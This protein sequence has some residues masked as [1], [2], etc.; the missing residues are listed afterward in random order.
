MYKKIFSTILFTLIFSC[1]KAHHIP[2]EPDSLKRYLVTV[3]IIG[4]GQVVLD[5]I[6]PELG[7]LELTNVTARAIETIDMWFFTN[8]GTLGD[9][10]TITF[11]VTE[12]LAIQALFTFDSP[13]SPTSPPD[14][15]EFTVPDWGVT[16][17]HPA[18]S[19]VTGS[20]FTI[21]ESGLYNFEALLRYSAQSSTQE[22][23]HCY[24]RVCNDSLDT[25]PSNPNHES[26]EFIVFDIH[27]EER[28]ILFKEAGQF[29]L[30]AGD[31][32][33]AAYHGST[34]MNEEFHGAN[35]VQGFAFKLSWVE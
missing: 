31:Y 32:F 30:S 16:V 4:Q 29:Q 26:G 28:I 1:S 18:I 23:E 14:S 6:Q 22:K 11:E 25:K 2:M 19:H 5:P 9:S 10:N 20:E 35:S 13:P 24:F 12:A 3:E 7:Y 34:K 21:L 15:I 8:F 33:I 17:S 27:N